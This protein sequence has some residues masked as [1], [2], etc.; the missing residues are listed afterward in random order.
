VAPGP[1]STRRPDDPVLARLLPDAYADPGAAGEF[2]RLTQDELLGGKIR[3]ISAVIDALRAAP[4]GH[5]V[6]DDDAA[7]TWLAALNDLRLA[8]GTRMGLRADLDPTPVPPG[9]HA[10][11]RQRFAFEWLGLLQETLVEAVAGPA[12][13]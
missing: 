10:A 9:E 8:V 13:D 2:R 3:R 6:L 4:G 1:E 11:A 5:V 12:G 7:E